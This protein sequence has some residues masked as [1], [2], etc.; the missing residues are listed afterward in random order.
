MVD[1]W[2]GDQDRNADSGFDLSIHPASQPSIQPAI[3]PQIRLDLHLPCN[4]R[5]DADE[6]DGDNCHD[7]I[8]LYNAVANDDDVGQAVEDGG[9]HALMLHGS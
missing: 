9:D 1:E 3:H 8:A 5:S 4:A 7:N 6:D 2:I